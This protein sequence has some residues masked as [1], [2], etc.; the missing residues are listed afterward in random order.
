MGPDAPG[1]E[2]APPGSYGEAPRG[3]RLPAAT[4]LGRVSLQVADLGRSLEFYQRTLGLRA[5]AHDGA[6]AVLASLGDDTPLVELREYP[7]A[8]PM[9]SR[10]RLG[11]YH[12]ALLLPDR[13]SLGRLVRHLGAIGARAVM[14]HGSPIMMTRGSSSRYRASASSV[15]ASRTARWLT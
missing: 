10:G 11:L 14:D 9:S 15:R 3:Y 4:R 5:I 2:P 6:G 13:E 8:R 12:F 7:G 1:V